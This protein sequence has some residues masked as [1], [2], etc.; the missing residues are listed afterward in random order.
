MSNSIG[1]EKLLL[2]LGVVK[3]H[4]LKPYGIVEAWYYDFL[5]STSYGGQW[6]ASRTG[7]FAP[8]EECPL[9]PLARRLVRP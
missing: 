9:Y 8:A 7:L 1:K 5:I 6:S 2:S 3:P 4:I